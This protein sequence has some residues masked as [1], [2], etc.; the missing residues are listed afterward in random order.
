MFIDR[1][2]NPTGKSLGNRQKFTRR[3]KAQIKEA[4]EKSLKDRSIKD[5]DKNQDISIPA[6]GTKEPFFH[7]S[8][9]GGTR[10]YVHPGNQDF[11]K[12]DRIRR[13][14]KGGGSGSGKGNPSDSGEGED[15]FTFTL[16]QDE[17][18]DVL[19]EGLELPNMNKTSMKQVTKTEYRRAGVTVSGAPTNLNLV[20]TMRNSFGRRLALKRPTIAE[21]EELT[22][23]MFALEMKSVKTPEEHEELKRVKVELERLKS[24]Q[25]WVPYIDP[26]DV[27]YN[28]FQKTIIPSSQAV[29]FCLMD[30]SGSMGEHE[31][32]L[33]KRFYVLLH[34][35]LK[36]K[37]EKVDVVFIRHTH[38]ADEVDEE[39]FFYSTQSGGTVV[40]TA[41][42]EMQKIYKS[43]YPIDEW[44][45]YAA[46]A[47]DGDAFGSDA[48]N[49]KNM[50][51]EDV[52]PQ[53]QYYT[54]IE[55]EDPR[56]VAMGMG[57]TSMWEQYGNIPKDTGKFTMSKVTESEDIIPVFREL[58]SKEENNV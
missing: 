17:V 25:K 36:R 15:E 2:K 27:R 52:L 42:E 13:P 46:Q 40:A 32:D 12:G 26:I 38:V 21:V 1:R 49:C 5:F 47:S 56:S 58:F 16:S 24:K 54:Y 53:C 37:Y 9:E 3:A 29:M 55:I 33:A 50:L 35:F 34:L 44:N 31:K 43:R 7:H 28:A 20:R 11:Q 8:S 10:D 18:L 14:E 19:F 41:L 6:Q 39:T 23:Q 48:E 22:E 51:I 57:D 4:V 45:I 30:V